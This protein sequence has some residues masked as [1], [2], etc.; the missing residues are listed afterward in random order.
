VA[1]GI[2]IYLSAAIT[3]QTSCRGVSL[4]VFNL[5]EQVMIPDVTKLIKGLKVVTALVRIAEDKWLC[6]YNDGQEDR[7][8]VLREMTP[9]S[10]IQT[11]GV[12]AWQW[13]MP[14][15]III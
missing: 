11:R 8:A 1:A 3:E 14:W 5:M 10:L 9:Q 2:Y 13:H 4:S 7:V 6:A 12:R 15:D